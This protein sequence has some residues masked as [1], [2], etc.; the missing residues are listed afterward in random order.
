MEHF[1]SRILFDVSVVTIG[2]L[3]LPLSAC[4]GSCVDVIKYES[5]AKTL[6]DLVITFSYILSHFIILSTS[7]SPN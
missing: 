3:S 7:V 1:I 5:L 4:V 2:S 6:Y